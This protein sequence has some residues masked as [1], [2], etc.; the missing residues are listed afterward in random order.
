MKVSTRIEP[1]ARD[2]ALLIGD[3]LSAEAQSRMLAE[4]AEDEIAEAERTNLLALGGQV[5]KEVFVDGRKGAALA[6]VRPD[7]VIVAEFDLVHDVVEWIGQQ[8]VLTSPRLSGD[9]AKSH[10]LFADG[11]ENK[12]GGSVPPASEYIFVNTQPYARKIEAGLSSQAPDGVYQSVAVVAARRFGNV[13]RVRFTY[14]S[15]TA[16]SGKTSAERQPAILVRVG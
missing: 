9:Y 14:R 8:L 15:I 10:V 1:I 5:D 12:V 6:S 2:I 7:G 16:G 11:V 13:A 3:D 4:F